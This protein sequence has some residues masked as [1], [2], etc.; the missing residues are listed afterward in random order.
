[1][2][3]NNLYIVVEGMV[4]KMESLKM[5]R[6]YSYRIGRIAAL[7]LSAAIF[8]CGCDK[9]DI[10]ETSESTSES[11]VTSEKQAEW[12]ISGDDDT[13]SAY[14]VTVNDVEITS[15]PQQVIC[16]SSSLTEIVCELEIAVGGLVGT[17]HNVVLL[18]A[19]LVSEHEFCVGSA[20]E[21]A[22]F[23]H[24]NLHNEGVRCSLYGEVLLESLVPRES[25][26]ER[27]CSGS[28]ALFV[29]D[30][31]R[32]GYFGSDLFSL[33]FCNERDFLCH[34]GISFL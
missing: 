11:E 34:D 5:R 19:H 28:D 26:V 33:F 23:L 20:V 2:S 8:L 3:Y 31:E 25:V 12:V 4:W 24:K 1:M 14:P 7:V 6:K 30:V 15:S 18:C 16:L 32:C 22:A 10:S 13:L 27:S 17:E 21:S 9:N 29:V